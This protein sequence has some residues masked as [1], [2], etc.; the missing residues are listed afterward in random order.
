VHRRGKVSYAGRLLYQT[1]SRRPTEKV[2]L[3][4]DKSRKFSG[5]LRESSK[6]KTQNYLFSSV[7]PPLG[8]DDNAEVAVNFHSFGDTIW[9]ARVI[10]VSGKTTT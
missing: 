6:T 2:K 5:F 8:K 3:I 10:D 1:C 7:D 9:V 4:L